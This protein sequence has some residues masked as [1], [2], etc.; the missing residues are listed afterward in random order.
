MQ[1]DDKNM[2]N[3]VTLF[4]EMGEHLQLKEYASLRLDG[5]ASTRSPPVSGTNTPAPVE[6]KQIPSPSSQSGCSPFAKV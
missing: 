4:F 3:L 1:A 2:E 5:A 6:P